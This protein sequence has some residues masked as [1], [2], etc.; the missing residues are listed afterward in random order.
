[1]NGK[2]QKAKGKSIY[3]GRL[4]TTFDFGHRALD[5][6]R[7]ASRS[8]ITL[9]EVLISMGVLV[10]GVLGAASLIPM[11]N[12]YQDEAQKFDRG[13]TLAE[14]AVHNLQIKNY[15]SPRRWIFVDPNNATG[16]PVGIMG[17]S[18]FQ[19]N[20]AVVLDPLGFSYTLAQTGLTSPF[21]C[22]FP[23]FPNQGKSP[24]GS[25]ATQ[26]A[27][28]VYRIGVTAND[29][30]PAAATLPVYPPVAMTYPVADRFFRSGDD[31]NYDLP[32]DAD[33]RPQA[34]SGTLQADYAGDY[35]W[36]AT[37]S[38]SPADVNSN[39][40]MHRFN[41]SSVVLQKRLLNLWAS[42]LDTKPPSERL[43]FAQ[44]MQFGGQAPATNAPFY[45][46]GSLLLYVYDNQ[47]SSNPNQ[48]VACHQWLQ[49]L[50]ANTYLMLSANFI[51]GMTATGGGTVPAYP[52]LG[53]Y[54]IV[55]VGDGPQ[56]DKTNS[57]L[58]TLRV[59]VAGD[60]WPAMNFLDPQNLTLS[61]LWLCADS[62]LATASPVAF[63]TLMDDAVAVYNENVT[64]DYSLVRE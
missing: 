59:T 61:P 9:L 63:C 10:I 20:S 7:E 33:Q 40:Q 38:R 14:Q 35:S 1:M 37:V 28:F 31:L 57:A 5:F 62:S 55:S 21:P 29:Y 53:W 54:K 45:G 51:D 44:F 22:F 4:A 36:I 24:P 26:N 52:R 48:S 13:A 17:L 23:A 18:A 42:A 50:K 11:A 12:F 3:A 64:L 27:P 47:N 56:Q 41:V 15:L 2:R 34:V 60:D 16:P 32:T 19:P 8:G 25:S 30:W 46:G 6:R 49:G 58:W 43:V 39:V